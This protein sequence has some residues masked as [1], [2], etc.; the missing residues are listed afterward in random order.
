MFL[1]KS[2]GEMPCVASELEKKHDAETYLSPEEETRIEEEKNNMKV[3]L[4]VNWL[5]AKQG[6]TWEAI[7]PDGV[8]EQSISADDVENYILEKIKSLQHI[9]DDMDKL[10]VYTD[11]GKLL[12][13]QAINY[14][15]DTNETIV[16][17]LP[18]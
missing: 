18:K 4:A 14:G 13:E 2:D 8:N 9:T 6:R 11:I 17:K 1:G 7:G 5:S 16:W 15:S 12:V 10:L 3:E